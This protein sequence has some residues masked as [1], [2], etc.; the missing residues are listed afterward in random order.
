MKLKWKNLVQCGSLDPSGCMIKRPGVRL[1]VSFSIFLGLTSS[2]DALA[3]STIIERWSLDKIVARATEKTPEIKA[4]AKDI[5]RAENIA[6]QA[7]KWD[8]PEAGISGGPMTQSGISGRAIDLSVKQSIP[9]FGQRAIAEKIG[10]QN[11]ITVEAESSKQILLLKYEVIRLAVRLAVFEEQ[12]KHIY[13]RRDK[14][15]VIAKYLD[16]RPFASP[17]QAVEKMLILNR[18]REIEEKFLEIST[19]RENAWKALNVFLALDSSIVPDVKWTSVLVIPNRENLL[20]HF[21]SLNPDL[22]RY[23]SLI[24]ASSL[25]ADQAGKKRFPDIRLGVGYN[26]QTADSPQRTYSGMLELSLPILDRGDYGKRAALAEKE[27]ATFRLEQKQRELQSQF[28]QNWANLLQSK[29]RVEIY[30]MSLVDSLENQMDRT[31]QNWKKGLVPV[32]SYLELENQVHEQVFKVYDAQA[33]YF[34]SLAQVQLV[35]GVD[36]GKEEK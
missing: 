20:N 27:A 21:E 17:A 4:L 33:A 14:I 22:Q 26:E 24:A 11:K 30:P 25:E 16:T 18:L 12:S 15:N 2:I 29:K 35:A 7:G 34:E 36:S 3:E 31:E 32:T 5:E 28:E 1:M 23:K 10:E 9:L 13:H 6:R 19:A 8:N